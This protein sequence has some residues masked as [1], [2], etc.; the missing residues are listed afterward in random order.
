MDVID[1]EGRRTGATKPRPYTTLPQ[2][3]LRAAEL[4]FPFDLSWVASSGNAY[5]ATALRKILPIPEHDYPRCGADWYL[6]H[7][8]SLLGPVVSLQDV[9]ASY[10]VHGHN[11]YEP[12]NLRLDLQHVRETIHYSRTTAR[13]LARLADEL[14]LEHPDP[15]MSL[16]DVGNRLI[17]HKL[18]PTL[19]PIP[20]DSAAGLVADAI[21]AAHRRFDISWPLKL[22]LVLWFVAIA[23][24]PRPVARVLAELFLFP[25]RRSSLNGLLSRL[26]R[27]P[28]R[29]PGSVNSPT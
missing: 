17:S 10:R 29:T 12:Q 14:A 23:V 25:E 4:T 15:I 9:G 24:A 13:A 16:S 11:R 2:G 28:G 26:H 8:T 3:D 6:I 19:H 18:E 22:M 7:L 21:R 1:A 20:T 5:R 27:D